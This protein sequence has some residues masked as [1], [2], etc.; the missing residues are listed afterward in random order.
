MSFWKHFVPLSLHSCRADRRLSDK[1]SCQISYT[2]PNCIRMQS[3]TVLRGS[4]QLCKE[5]FNHIALFALKITY[6]YNLFDSLPVPFYS[7]PKLHYILLLHTVYKIASTQ[8]ALILAGEKA[9]IVSTICICCVWYSSKY[10]TVLFPWDVATMRL[11]RCASQVIPLK[12]GSINAMA[13]SRTA[14]ILRD[15]IIFE[16]VAGCPTDIPQGSYMTFTANTSLLIP[17]A[18]RLN[19]SFYLTNIRWV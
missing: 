10:H 14:D 11:H 1:L 19:R 16:Y 4:L 3:I 18:F 17:I 8:V 7:S 9:L 2:L 12:N 6:Q 15:M 13:P 5:L